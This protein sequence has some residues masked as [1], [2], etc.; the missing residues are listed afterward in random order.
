MS[1]YRRIATT[2][3]YVLAL[4]AIV[5]LAPSAS[6]PHDAH[7]AGPRTDAGIQTVAFTEIWAACG[8]SA[9]EDKVV[10]VFPRKPPAPGPQVSAVLLCGSDRYGYRHIAGNHG[11][12]WQNIAFYTGENWRFLADFAIE[13][14]LT[15]PEPGYPTYRK[16][17][18]TWTYRAPLEIRDSSGQVRAT[19]RPVIS[20]SAR[21]G[22][23]ITAFPSR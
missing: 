2:S 19:Y 8:R 5:G 23:I 17:N 20:V 1:R 9:P 10:R 6:S 22:K 14:I 11:M 16:D 7:R 21:D 3:A 15:F 13:Q 12:D 4:V 18:D